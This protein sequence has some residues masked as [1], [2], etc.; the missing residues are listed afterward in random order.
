MRNMTSNEAEKVLKG[1]TLKVYKFVLKK[2]SPTG[3]REVQRGLKLSSPTL[4]S[5]HLKKLEDAGLLKQSREGY[6]VDRV[7]LRNLVRFRRMLIPKYFF[8]SVFFSL[9]LALEVT[10]FKPT[11]LS[12]EYVFAIGITCVAVLSYVYETI[13]VLFKEGI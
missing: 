8:Y 7:F 13:R 2:G 12:R 1:L 6:V 9:A 5:Y 11:V 3:I 4:A 10:V